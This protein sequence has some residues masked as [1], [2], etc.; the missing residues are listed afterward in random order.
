MQPGVGA[1]AFQRYIWLTT[2][3]GGRTDRWPG[4]GT[5]ATW[6]RHVS[7][8]VSIPLERGEDYVQRWHMNVS[9]REVGKENA[10]GLRAG[11]HTASTWEGGRD[12]AWPLGCGSHTEGQVGHR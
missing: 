12:P 8:R 5:G 1:P 11:V 4:W 2:V 6:L 9:W 10:C 7:L 3:G